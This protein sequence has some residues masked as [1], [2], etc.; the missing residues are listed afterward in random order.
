ML[1]TS[2]GLIFFLKR[3][4]PEL[5]Q[6]ECAMSTAGSLSMASQKTSPQ[7]ASGIR[8]SGALVLVGRQGTRRTLKT[9]NAYLDTLTS[10]IYEAK[11]RSLDGD[12]EV[13]SEAIKNILLG[14]TEGKEKPS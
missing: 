9:L 6:T 8:L 14:R 2:F 1:E 5:V 13:N 10:K 12:K 11:K 3:P 4:N 7:N